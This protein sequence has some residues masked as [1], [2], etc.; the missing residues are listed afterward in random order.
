MFT[1]H[2]TLKLLTLLAVA[3]AMTGC[4]SRPA[5]APQAAT[6]IDALSGA[7][8]VRIGQIAFGLIFGGIVGNLVDRLLPSRHEVIDFIYFFVERG[9]GRE[10]G[11]PAFNIADSGICVGVALV[12]WLTWKGDRENPSSDVPTN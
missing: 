3:A 6:L 2:P 8:E 7:T 11:F 10:L 5:P 9:D 12:F 4:T 1:S